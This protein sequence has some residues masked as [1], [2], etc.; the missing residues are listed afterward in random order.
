MANNGDTIATMNEMLKTDFH[1]VF[2]K[3]QY[4]G[5]KTNIMFWNRAK[6]RTVGGR[7]A[8]ATWPVD[9]EIGGGFAGL[10]EGGDHATGRPDYAKVYTLALADY[11][12]TFEVTRKALSNAKKKGASYVDDLIKR[13]MRNLL[14][15]QQFLLATRM[16]QAGTGLVGQVTAVSSNVITIDTFGAAHIRKGIRLDIRSATTSGTARFTGDGGRVE[17]VDRENNTVEVSAIGTVQVGDFVYFDGLYEMPEIQGI[18]K[19]VSQTGEFQGRN[20][21][22]V[23]NDDAKCYRINRGGGVLRVRD[24]MDLRNRRHLMPDPKRKPVYVCHQDTTLDL[25]ELVADQLRYTETSDFGLGFDTMSIHTGSGK[26][27]VVEERLTTPG[28]IWDIDPS[29]FVRMCPQGSEGG[30]WMDED[31]SVLKAK[32]GTTSNAYADSLVAHRSFRA[33]LG[34]DAPWMNAYLDNYTT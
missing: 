23:G 15:N 1:D 31:G 16:W 11:S 20:R 5:S 9:H 17:G 24:L 25:H 4:Y 12:L 8:T 27:A 10:T 22:T 18:P 7:S 13:K 29:S 3:A 19:I 34:C 26:S 2:P 32:Q 6:K 33:N 28:T 14:N 30:D 21:A